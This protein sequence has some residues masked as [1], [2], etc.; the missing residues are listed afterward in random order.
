[1]TDHKRSRAF[2]CLLALRVVLSAH[3]MLSSIL[4]WLYKRFLDQAFVDALLFYVFVSR[5]FS[6]DPPSI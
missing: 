6:G 3:C 5:S 2:N 4:A 1:M